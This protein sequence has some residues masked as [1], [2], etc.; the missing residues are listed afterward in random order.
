VLLWALHQL[1]GEL[2]ALVGLELDEER[3]SRA[4]RNACLAGCRALIIKGDVRSLPLPGAFDLVI[5]NPPFF[6]K[7]WGRQSADLQTAKATHALQG[8]IDDFCRAA[9]QALRAHGQ[10]LFLYDTGRLAELLLA[11]KRAGLCCRKLRFLRDDRG[12][13]ARLLALSGKE[14]AGLIVEEEPF[15]VKG[16]V[17]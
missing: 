6:P 7:G 9:A 2:K 3:T 4:Q 17:R 16:G 10:A 8:E 11:L 15:M 1:E 12:K 14:G 13:P 5:S